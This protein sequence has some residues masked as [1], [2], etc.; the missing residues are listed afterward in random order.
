[1]QNM[2][3]RTDINALRAIAVASV[4]LFHFFPNLL[5]GGFAGVDIFFVIS[6]YLMTR[7]ICEKIDRNN[8]S[9]GQFYLSR[10]NRIIPALVVVCLAVLV[11]GWFYLGP[12]DLK[13][14][15]KHTAK[16]LSF[17]SNLKYIEEAGYFDTASHTKWLL[18]TW[19]LSVEWQF[20]II[21]P[22]LILIIKRLIPGNKVFMSLCLLTLTSFV[23]SIYLSFT[24]PTEAYF[25]LQTRIWQM[26]LGGIAYL[27]PSYWKIKRPRELFWLGV[28]AIVSTFFIANSKTTWPGYLAA[29]PCA[30]ALLIIITRQNN[31]L[32]NNIIIQKLGLWSY[33]IY[34]WH[35][36]VSVG[37]H[38]FELTTAERWA[39]LLLSVFFGFCS[40]R[41]IESI[42][43]KQQYKSKYG[44][45][46]FK[47]LLFLIVAFLA[48][49]AI[50]ITDG[51]LSHYPDSIQLAE[52]ASHD[53]NP[54]KCM[55]RDV[56]NGQFK[57]CIIG[58][59]DKVSAIVVG[60]SHA[61]A[62]TTSISPIFTQ[63]EESILALT[64]ISCPFILG[65]KDKL[66]P[67]DICRQDN[68]KRLNYIQSTFP[69]IPVI[70]TSRLT[71]YIYGQSNPD[72]ITTD[73]SPSIY[74]EQP[75][76]AVNQD[77]L[78]ETEGHMIKTL[79]P[80]RKTNPVYITLP[81]PEMG[82]NI[83]KVFIKDL[84]KNEKLSSDYSRDISKYYERNEPIIELTQRVA[85]S[86]DLVIIDPKEALCD[87]TSC[88]SHVN[89]HPIYYDGDHLNEFGN[90]LLTPLFKK[91]LQQ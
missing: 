89:G 44:Y 27:L 50:V 25:Q 70:V 1:M 72:R 42:R 9:V 81:I 82:R 38:Y 46:K 90:K 12:S 67:E 30:G 11:F 49:R 20:Y 80:L 68:E 26:T 6:G 24:N 63:R 2:N 10:A 22:I 52:H 77:L 8:F 47:P 48:S 51:A 40:F 62:I 53:T 28:V 87:S 76:D 3:F 58:S 60:D 57:P 54:H 37:G 66:Q 85:K 91:A 21:Y 5:P 83:P 69:N 78:S 45:L 15:G 75:Y 56:K 79:C 33:S 32:T 59:S 88:I 17:T 23:Y 35:W 39:A 43:F 34:L 61:D 55:A 7:I 19:S 16:S 71:A 4:T 36:P 29:L 74:F 84:L 18:H 86:C 31:L 64:R 14:L 73:N 13:L 65:A 41:F